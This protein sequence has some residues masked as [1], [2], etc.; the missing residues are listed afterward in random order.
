VR[1]ID[2]LCLK[3]DIAR[4]TLRARSARPPWSSGAAACESVSRS[5][6]SVALDERA[7]LRNCIDPRA[8]RPAVPL[9][10]GT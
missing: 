10:E 8:D 1:R 9:T 7:F 2:A 5:V 6:G 4:G 3:G